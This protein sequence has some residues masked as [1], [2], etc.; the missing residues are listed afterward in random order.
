MMMIHNDQR[1]ILP[2]IILKWVGVMVRIRC[3]LL[4]MF[5]EKKNVLFLFSKAFDRLESSSPT[6][7]WNK[8]VTKNSTANGWSN[9]QQTNPSR[10]NP[11]NNQWPE[12]NNIYGAN[13]STDPFNLSQANTDNT[14]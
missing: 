13:T 7:D 8:P 2:K 3:F 6:S 5:R 14:K 4:H 12:M 10:S 11:T 1:T 9:F